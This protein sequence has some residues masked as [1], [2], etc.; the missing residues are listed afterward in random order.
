MFYVQ[1]CTTLKMLSSV[2]SFILLPPLFKETKNKRNI[3]M[4]IILGVHKAFYY[5]SSNHRVTLCI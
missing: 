2:F 4:N 5:V 3:K 1:T